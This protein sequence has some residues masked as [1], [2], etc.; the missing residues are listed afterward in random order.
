MFGFMEKKTE[1]EFN[2][3]SK[4]ITKKQIFKL[5]EYDNLRK[6]LKSLKEKN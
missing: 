6:I 5:K 3:D 2:F 4:K 1:K